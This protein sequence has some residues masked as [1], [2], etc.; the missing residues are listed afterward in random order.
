MFDYHKAATRKLCQNYW[1]FLLSFNIS[2]GS[3]FQPQRKDN[4]NNIPV[5]RFGSFRFD[6]RILSSYPESGEDLHDLLVYGHSRLELSFVFP[7]LKDRV[8]VQT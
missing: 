4:G 7:D 3:V 1:S 8:F 5:F 6:S 2:L